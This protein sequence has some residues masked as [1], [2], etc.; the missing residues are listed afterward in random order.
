M[1]AAPSG[2]GG[3]PW[4]Q[5]GASIGSLIGNSASA[6][7]GKNA[8]GQMEKAAKQAMKQQQRA[9]GSNVLMQEPARNIGYQAYGDIASALGYSMPGYTPAN[10]LMASMNPLSAKTVSAML[11]S[12]MTLEQIASQGTLQGLTPKSL[13]RLQAAGLTPEQI[14]SLQANQQNAAASTNPTG[15]QSSG[16]QDFS[17]F[18]DSPD[19]QFRLNEGT[20]NVGNSFA[21]RG[22]ALSGN[23]L[24]AV[25]DYAQ[26]TAANEYGNW[27]NRRLGLAGMGNNAATNV[28]NSA[29]GTANNMGQMQQ[30]M[31][32]ARASGIMGIGNAVLNH[33]NDLMQIWGMGQGGSQQQ[34]SSTQQY[35]NYGPYAGAYRW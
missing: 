6:I 10:Q 12:G 18:Y 13:K 26:N 7:A 17:R 24:R 31:G 22:G 11:K 34:P 14:Q 21:A 5:I 8:A 4:S 30:A 23:A 1:T 28:A 16:T 25:N 15:Q 20:R 27:F 3:A 9:Y 29:T 33:S 35:S 19:Y 32:D 2:G